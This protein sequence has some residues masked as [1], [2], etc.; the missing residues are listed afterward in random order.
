MRSWLGKH[1]VCFLCYIF[2]SGDSSSIESRALRGTR[3]SFNNQDSAESDPLDTHLRN[4]TNIDLAGSLRRYE[5][6]KWIDESSRTAD[7]GNAGSATTGASTEPLWH[8]DFLVCRSKRLA[9]VMAS[10]LA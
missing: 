8:R 7:D 10:R 4:S 5:A 1:A 6:A 2:L 3:S 9:L